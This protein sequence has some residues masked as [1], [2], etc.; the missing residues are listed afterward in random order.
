M[1]GNEKAFQSSKQTFSYILTHTKVYDNPWQIG[2]LSFLLKTK[3]QEREQKITH[4]L[5]IIQ[6][7]Q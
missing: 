4:F 2:T 6:K 7:S 5:S 3:N 1:N